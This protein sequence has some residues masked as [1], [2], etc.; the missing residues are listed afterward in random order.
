MWEEHLLDLLL[1][2]P[3]AVWESNR[4]KAR[5]NVTHQR[6]GNSVTHHRDQPGPHKSEGKLPFQ[7]GAD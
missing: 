7:Q 4:E 1:Q 5:N 2:D 3:P 6:P